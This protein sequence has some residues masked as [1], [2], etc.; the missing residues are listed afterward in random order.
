L[1]PI[2]D[3]ERLARTL[4]RALLELIEM[5]ARM[6]TSINRNDRPN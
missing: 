5:R 4:A 3:A 2:A 6:F 1:F